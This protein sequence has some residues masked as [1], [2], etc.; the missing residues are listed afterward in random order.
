MNRSTLRF[1]TTLGCALVGGA[2]LAWM[3]SACGSGT[4]G[5]QAQQAASSA[6]SKA[7][8]ALSSTSQ[9]AKDP[10]TGTTA[11]TT[12]PGKTTTVTHTTTV[13]QPVQT[14]TTTKTETTPGRTTSITNKTTTVVAT[15]TS[16]TGSAS[17][18]G[19]PTWGWV[20]IALG[21]VGIAIGTFLVGRGRR[22]DA[23]GPGTGPPSGSVGHGP[24][25]S[26]VPGSTPP[27]TQ[28]QEGPPQ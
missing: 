15:P 10:S 8:G 2:A 23:G 16:T 3:V 11:T 5:Q 14:V 13:T 25:G 20:L 19:V 27:P 7:T 6:A 28:R 26:D 21:V 9:S 18:S 22:G 12:S 17:G 4:A 1:V 24:A